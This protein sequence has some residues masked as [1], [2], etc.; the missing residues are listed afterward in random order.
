MI[1]SILETSSN[2]PL[3][4]FLLPRPGFSS[5][6]TECRRS[7]LP[8]MSQEATVTV[9]VVLQHRLTTQALNHH[10]PAKHI[11]TLSFTYSNANAHPAT[12]LP[13]K[14]RSCRI[15]LPILALQQLAHSFT[16]HMRSYSK[17]TCLACLD[18]DACGR[19]EHDVQG[20]KRLRYNYQE[21]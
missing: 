17:S 7:T 12:P 18:Q 21:R 20:A 14:F 3:H 13:H 6:F 8:H 1:I 19:V 10:G 16:A 9:A 11:P 15:A 5:S 2:L 4:C